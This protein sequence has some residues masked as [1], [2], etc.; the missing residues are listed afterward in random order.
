MASSPRSTSSPARLPRSRSAASRA[1]RRYRCA[2]LALLLATTP[3]EQDDPENHQEQRQHERCHVREGELRGAKH[4]EQRPDEGLPA[5]AAAAGAAD[6]RNEQERHAIGQGPQPVELT[7]RQRL[8]Q[9]GH[10]GS[11]QGGA[12]V[13]REASTAHRPGQQEGEPAGEHVHAVDVDVLR[14]HASE[15][16]QP[17]EDD[18]E[19][20]DP[21][22]LW[23][24]ILVATPLPAVASDRPRLARRR[25]GRARKRLRFAIRRVHS[26]LLLAACRQAGAVAG[27][28]DSPVSPPEAA[29][30]SSSSS[31][32]LNPKRSAMRRSG[33]GAHQFQ[34]PRSRIVAGTSSTR[35]IVASR[36]TARAMPT[37]MLLIVIVSAS[38]KAAKTVT[39]MSAAPVMTP[40]VFASPSAT[41]AALS[42][43]RRYASWT[44]DRSRTS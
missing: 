42:P 41:A 24:A 20:A 2:S 15:E 18:E 23:L 4:H 21:R 3:R 44:R 37:P 33:P 40:A 19:D 26:S 36:A 43:V 17:A 13:Q 14:E 32:W 5:D 30:R 12:R 25:L 31:T 10:G 8:D 9:A 16:Q 6:S 38:A 27:S 29:A 22:Q 7:P 35:T 11:R 1:R 34:F 39:M 28:A